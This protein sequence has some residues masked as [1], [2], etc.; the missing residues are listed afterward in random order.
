MLKGKSKLILMLALSIL[1]YI[2]AIQFRST[3]YSRRQRLPVSAEINVL[4]ENIQRE[5]QVEQTLIEQIKNA[6]KTNRSL[7]DYQALSNHNDAVRSL[8]DTRDTLKHSI[9]LTDVKGSGI[10]IELMDA[11]KEAKVSP[12]LAIIHYS[13]VMKVVNEL[14]KAG[15]QAI[16]INDERVIWSSEQI[17]AGPTIRINNNRYP[18][19]YIIKSTGDPNQLYEGVAKSG[20][21]SAL[22]E[23]KIRVRIEKS[24]EVVIP[25]YRHNTDNLINGLEVI[26]SE[27]G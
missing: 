6:E 10:I 18:I 23:A 12:L 27:T 1:G 25:A 9:G 21:V 17:C 8:I 16:C 20:I 7:L 5:K 22:F 11:P 26:D 15:A 2:L 13:D 14:K 19:P 3:L 24:K 4:K